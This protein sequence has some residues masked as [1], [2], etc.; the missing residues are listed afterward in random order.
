MSFRGHGK[1][2]QLLLQGETDVNAKGGF[3]GNALQ[4]ASF[5]G[6]GE[7]VQ[8]LM[9]AGADVR[10]QDGFYGNA[11]VGHMELVQIFL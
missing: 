2:V 5:A 9:Q 3:F 11:S 4:A 6:H 10:A 8:L 1:I 7:I